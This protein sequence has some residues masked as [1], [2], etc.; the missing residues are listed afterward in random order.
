MIERGTVDIVDTLAAPF[1]VAV[2]ADVLGVPRAD[3]AQFRRWSDAIVEGLAVADP[4]D[5]ERATRCVEGIT[6]LQL[7]L[8]ALVDERRQQ[9]GEDMLAKLSR[10]REDGALTPNELFWFCLLLLVAG[11][12]TTTNLIGN[13][14]LTLLQHPGQWDVL[15]ARPDLVAGAVEESVRRDA[16]IQGLFRT[17]VEPYATRRGEIPAGGRVLLLFGAANR[18]PDHYDDPDRFDPERGAADHLGFGS[19][20][21]LCLGAHLARLEGRA[22]FTALLERVSR[23]EPAGDAVRGTNPALRGLAHLPM[24]LVPA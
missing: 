14:M 24:R 20:I 4:S 23:V 21:H 16:P 3:H 1:P 12:E 5:M 7:Y 15:R 10:P 8:T 9:G 13:L 6:Q 19:G 18:D 2:I 22:V 11:N 17:A